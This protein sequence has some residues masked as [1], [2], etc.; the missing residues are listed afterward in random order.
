MGFSHLDEV[1]KQESVR[2]GRLVVV[3]AWRPPVSV[4]SVSGTVSL[5]P[6]PTAG[7]GVAPTLPQE[8]W[9]M[10]VQN[11]QLG[12]PCWDGSSRGLHTRG[13]SGTTR[14]S[15]RCRYRYPLPHHTPSRPIA[16]RYRAPPGSINTCL[17]ALSSPFV[18]TE[19]EASVTQPSRVPSLSMSSTFS[20]PN[21]GTSPP[22]SLHLHVFPFMYRCRRSL[23][24][25]V[26]GAVV[27]R[28]KKWPGR[29][30]SGK[31]LC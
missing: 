15:S 16:V 1:G 25:M 6:S 11:S 2:L 26:G 23:T 5:D 29:L 27:C 3:P 28:A 10:L 8:I 30:V 21:R 24:S 31:M 19:K 20:H 9:F 14:T 22:V 13:G 17:H 12:R 4:L 18:R 7:A